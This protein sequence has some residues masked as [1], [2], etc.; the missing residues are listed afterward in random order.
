MARKN[1][2]RRRAFTLVELLVVIGII[3]LLISI[4]LP[5]LGKARR[6]ASTAKCL[7]T[8]RQL[9]LAFQMYTQ[10]NKGKSI[11]YYLDNAP[12]ELGLWIGQLRG[13]YSNINQ[14]RLCP[15]AIEDT[16]DPDGW[17]GTFQHWGPNPGWPIIGKQTGSYAFNGWL[18]Y[19]NIQ[20]ERWI[21][22]G[23]FPRSFYESEFFNTP[24]PRSAEVP[25]FMDSTWV[26]TWPSASDGPPTTLRPG[27]G[28]LAKINVNGM[29]RVCIAR[30]NEA[31]N[32][33][34]CDGHAATVPLQQL[35]SLY[36]S[37][38]YVAPKPLPTL[39]KS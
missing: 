21:G 17:G 2:R 29:G 25:C 16:K 37:P 33:A 24:I 28:D 26:D 32:V 22:G 39:P 31:I 14:S 6:A 34:F 23:A 15:D 18:Y 4:L 12:E 19:Y 7:A 30:H 38:K 11:P 5:V 35:W 27:A 10:A 20:G 8:V 3:A 36:W 9:G 13:V 1:P